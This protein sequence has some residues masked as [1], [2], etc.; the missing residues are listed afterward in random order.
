MAFSK[1][2]AHLRKAAARNFED[3]TEAIGNI[4]KLY[5]PTECWNFFKAADYVAE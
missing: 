3:L 1:L 4:C 2:K 5:S